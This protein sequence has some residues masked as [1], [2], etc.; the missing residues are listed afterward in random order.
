M[1]AI[2]L[3]QRRGGKLSGKSRE[4]CVATQGRSP[5]QLDRRRMTEKKITKAHTLSV[6]EKESL[7][8]SGKTA[9][10]ECLEDG[11]GGAVLALPTVDKS[12]KETD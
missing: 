12:E 1:P 7:T 11:G 6:E 10:K 9:E 8:Q 4:S 5:E 2:R 3:W